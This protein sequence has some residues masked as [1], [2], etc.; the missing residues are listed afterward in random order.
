[1]QNDAS[2]FRMPNESASIPYVIAWKELL[3]SQ[4]CIRAGSGPPKQRRCFVC[5]GE[6]ICRVW[7]AGMADKYPMGMV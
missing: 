5:D 6:I 1:M 2:E 7:W 4:Y 3:G